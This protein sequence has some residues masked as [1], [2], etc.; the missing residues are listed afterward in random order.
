MRCASAGLALLLLWVA[1]GNVT[2]Q[3]LA[4]IADA[5]PAIVI[6]APP[7][8]EFFSKL[9]DFHGIPIKAPAV[10]SNDAL[11]AAYD[12]LSML[13]SNQP[14]VVSNLVAA[15]AQFHIIGR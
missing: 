14:V 3:S 10:V 5:R 7:E 1:S 15:G 4:K 13:L 2:S 6:F 11:Y 8:K 9:L 12:R